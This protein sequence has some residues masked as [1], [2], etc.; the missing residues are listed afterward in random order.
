MYRTQKRPKNDIHQLPI[1]LIMISPLF[2][3]TN[4]AQFGHK[5]KPT[6]WT[7]QTTFPDIQIV[8]LSIIGIVLGLISTSSR[9]LEFE[10]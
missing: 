10:I 5:S 8:I 9:Q 1:M 2:K 3:Q 7:K 4:F 6:K